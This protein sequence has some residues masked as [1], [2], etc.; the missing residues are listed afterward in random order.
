[1]EEGRSHSLQD[2]RES[3]DEFLDMYSISVVLS[4]NFFFPLGPWQKKLPI[5]DTFDIKEEVFFGTKK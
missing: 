4:D 3:G 1:M 5:V 2:G